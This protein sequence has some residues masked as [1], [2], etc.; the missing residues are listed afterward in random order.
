MKRF[1]T[2]WMV[3]GIALFWAA[4][5][6]AMDP[7]DKCAADKIKT[8]GKYSSCLL[9]EESKAIKRGLDPD[10]AKCNSK[11]IGKWAKI[12]ERGLLACPTLGDQVPL[13]EQ[14]G[15]DVS[16]IIAGLWGQSSLGSGVIDT[17]YDILSIEAGESRPISVEA[18]DSW[19]DPVSFTAAADDGS[20]VT[21]SETSA[22]SMTVEAVGQFCT[23]TITLTSMP[24]TEPGVTKTLQVKV[25]DP[26]V[27][28]IGRDGRHLLIKYVDEFLCRWH[29]R[30]SGAAIELEFD[31]P[32]VEPDSECDAD[33]NACWYPLGSMIIRYYA[34]GQNDLP[35]STPVELIDATAPR[36]EVTVLVKELP[37]DPGTTAPPALMPPTGWVRLWDTL[38]VAGEDYQASL[39]KALCPTDY[40]QIGVVAAPGSGSGA[41]V[42]SDSDMRCVY[43]DYTIVAE[44]GDVV[45]DDAYALLVNR[46][47]PPQIP[48]LA[49][50][51]APLDIDG[52]VGCRYSIPESCQD[53]AR[54][55]LVPL[56]VA[57][58]RDSKL[59]NVSLDQNGDI[60]GGD[61]RYASSIRIPFT[62]MPNLDCSSNFSLCRFNVESSPFYRLKREE[63]YAKI[64]NMDNLLS[65]EKAI[66]TITYN[67]GFS[68]TDTEAYSLSVGLKITTHGEAS[69]GVDGLEA[70]GGWSVEVSTQFGWDWSTA[71]NY[72]TATA[73]TWQMTCPAF[74]Y[75]VAAQVKTR[76]IAFSEADTGPIVSTPLEGGKNSVKWLQYP[77]VFP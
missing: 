42:P 25:Y 52:V 27:M 16:R 72:S 48:S 4:G 55:L 2:L 45:V 73:L 43:K 47:G 1:A 76:F 49:G 31:H 60:V 34:W 3:L 68:Q 39:W 69:F 38:D 66:Q 63:A 61:I 6:E 20:C 14:V 9:N 23:E 12:E 28:D 57:E 77:A 29:D 67:T 74:T 7:T 19:R 32:Y 10:F 18:V 40:F 15:S 41:P 36:K 13:A 21:I 65:G 71:R 46:V 59:A 56:E 70:G 8:A 58:R 50:D 30:G 62:L 35:T 11:L 44:I 22:N 64:Q 5:A 24:T 26:M 37:P 17:E 54:L 75:G 51:R 33:P 53:E